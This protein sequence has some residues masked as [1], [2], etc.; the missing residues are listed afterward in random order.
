MKLFINLEM[1]VRILN[2]LSNSSKLNFNHGKASFLRLKTQIQH[3]KLDIL[4]LLIGSIRKVVT[5][6]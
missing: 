4:I 1:D 5:C 6:N 3:R 2:F